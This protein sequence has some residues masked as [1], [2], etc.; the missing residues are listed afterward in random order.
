M[1]AVHELWDKITS[2]LDDLAKGQAKMMEVI[3]GLRQKQM[4]LEKGL[5]GVGGRGQD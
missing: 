1:T 5:A 3:D 2:R 4:E